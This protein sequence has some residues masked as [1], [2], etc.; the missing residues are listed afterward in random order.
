MEG[1][2][3]NIVSSRQLYLYIKAARLSFL[4][5]T[6]EVRTN[7]FVNIFQLDYVYIKEKFHRIMF[8]RLHYFETEQK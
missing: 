7:F 8:E 5:Q 4:K 6:T 2:A 1:S 3:Y